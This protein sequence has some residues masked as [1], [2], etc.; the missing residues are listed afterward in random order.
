[1]S[2]DAE[3]ATSLYIY[4]VIVMESLLKKIH[5]DK[6]VTLSHSGHLLDDVYDNFCMSAHSLEFQNKLK[7]FMRT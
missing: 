7:S 5:V 1:M 6:C 2:L 4:F 3:P